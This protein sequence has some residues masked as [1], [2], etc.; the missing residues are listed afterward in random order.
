VVDII[1]VLYFIVDQN[2]PA[3]KVDDI[4]LGHTAV[5]N[6]DAAHQVKLLVQ[7]IAAN[8]FK[9]IMA[10]VKQLLLEKL[11]GI[12]KVSRV[13]RAHTFKELNQR[14]LCNRLIMRQIP[15]RFLADSGRDKLPVWVIVDVTEQCNQLL[16]RASFDR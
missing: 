11:P 14:S 6:R 5:R 1:L 16:I 3:D 8:S 4:P 15:F 7:L 2:H 9:V 13:A 10:A 12:L